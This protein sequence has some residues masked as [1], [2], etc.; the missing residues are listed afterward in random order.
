MI[1]VENDVFDY[2]YTALDGLIPEGNFSSEYVPAPTS[3]PF[4]TLIEEDNYTDTRLRGTAEQEEFA[5]LMYEANVYTEDKQAC[6]RLMDV[7]DEA[8]VQL[9]FQRISMRFV[10]NLEDTTIYRMVGR[11]RAGAN[12][13]KTIFRR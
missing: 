12:Q 3:L 5:V 9:G 2:V 4:A 1:D 11:Y 6:R 8:L 13:D 10:P 7:I